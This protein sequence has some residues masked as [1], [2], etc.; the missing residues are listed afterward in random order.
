MREE[1][2]EWIEVEKRLAGRGSDPHMVEKLRRVKDSKKRRKRLQ[3]S[4]HGRGINSP[5]K[6]VIQLTILNGVP[7]FAPAGSETTDAFIF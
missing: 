3:P 6:L 7:G 5:L 1:K 2:Q 4:I